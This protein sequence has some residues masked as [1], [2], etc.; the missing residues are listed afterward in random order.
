MAFADALDTTLQREQRNHD[1]KSPVDEH[2]R[3]QISDGHRLLDLTRQKRLRLYGEF[4]FLA[5]AVHSDPSFWINQFVPALVDRIS[6]NVTL[7][8]N[9]AIGRA[10]KNAAA[11]DVKKIGVAEQIAEAFF[12]NRW[13]KIREENLPRPVLRDQVQESLERDEPLELV[14]PIF[15]RKPFSPLKNRGPYPD[16]GELLSLARCTEA[17]QTVNSLSPTGCRLTLLAD[18]LKYNRACRTPDDVVRT[19][20]SALRAWKSL[21]ADDRVVCIANYEQWVSDRLPA[22]ILAVRS[23]TYQRYVDELSALYGPRFDADTAA[24]SLQ[25]IAAADDV[26][27]QLAFTFRS[28]VTSVN[29]HRLFSPHSPPQGGAQ[30]P[31]YWSDE[32]QR[33][34]VYFAASL[35]RSLRDLAM[36]REFFASFGYLGAAD[37]RELFAALRRDAFA[38][39]IR[40]VSISLTDR[41]L[42][43]LR[44]ILPRAIKLTIHGKP[45]E[46]HF[47]SASHRDPNITA[48]HSTGGVAVDAD[49]AQLN[50]KYRLEREADDEIPVLVAAPPAALHDAAA[51]EPLRRLHEIGQPIG[52]IDDAAAISDQTL[53]RML[54]ARS[55]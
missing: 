49:G 38:A 29:Y 46:L 31:R 3:S 9:A 52:Y 26:G 7:R 35:H 48:Q 40:Y 33:L 17:A 37:F 23:P 32:M 14:F 45:G 24:D 55:L 10:R 1:L 44:Q 36:P 4:E 54:H 27:R 21:I 19:Y 2:R 15:S 28:I 6:E 8:V 50:L 41:D 11:Y 43:V 39:A 34:Y 30:I 16:L 5:R 25:A 18:G 20:Q 22:G 13:Y 51:Y 53:H 12:D 47:L 42:G